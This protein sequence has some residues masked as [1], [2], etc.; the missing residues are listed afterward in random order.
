MN[1]FSLYS[2]ICTFWVILFSFVFDGDVGLSPGHA[3]HRPAV[4]GLL[5][6]L[7]DGLV[8]GF[9][10]GLPCPLQCQH[11]T[12]PGLHGLLPFAEFHG[13]SEAL[14]PCENKG[15]YK[16]QHQWQCCYKN[17][18]SFLNI[19]GHIVPWNR[20][21]RKLNSLNLL[22]I[23]NYLFTTMPRC[24]IISIRHLGEWHYYRGFYG[25]QRVIAAKRFRPLFDCSGRRDDTLYGLSLRGYSV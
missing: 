13:G 17:F 2:T 12:G 22:T 11:K 21:I 9:G 23:I 8:P 5:L 25:K 1:I 10:G 20:P 4:P 16:H 15:Q 24:A 3:C 6:H 7:G 19:H 14:L 18:S